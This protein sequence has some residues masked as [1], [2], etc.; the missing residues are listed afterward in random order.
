MKRKTPQPLSVGEE[1]FMLHCRAHGLEPVR[2]HTFCERKWRFDF[3]FPARKI[4]VEVE[5]G[6]AFGRGRHTSHTGFRGD[7]RKYNR[8]AQE[9]WLVLRYT[10]DMVTRG[11]AITEVLSVLHE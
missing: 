8:A 11:E 6:A 5:G 7:I 4:A 10:T 1:T 9:G 2:E 3:A